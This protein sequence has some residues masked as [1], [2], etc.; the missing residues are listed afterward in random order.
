MYY[1][2]NICIETSEILY[3]IGACVFIFLQCL[4]C[5]KCSK[6]KLYTMD[7]GFICIKCI[8]VYFIKTSLKIRDFVI[9]WRLVV[10][11]CFYF[12]YT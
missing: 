7:Y 1:V 2:D 12:T 10:N 8:I 5:K 3:E 6:L 11:T 9:L 4:Y